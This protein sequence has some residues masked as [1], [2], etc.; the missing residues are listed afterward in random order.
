MIIAA[1]SG[2][3]KT[4]L[5]K[6]YPQKVT[7]FVCMPYKNYLDDEA[8]NNEKGKANPDN[9]LRLEWPLNYVNA[10]VENDD[11]NRILLIPS[12]CYVLL[13]LQCL[14]IPYTLC[15]PQRKAKKVY[16]KRFIKRGNTKDFIDIFIGGWDKF[17]DGLE[18][19]SYGR[20]VVLKLNQFLSDVIDVEA[21]NK[22]KERKYAQ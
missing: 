8:E 18:N 17:M 16:H 7:D 20:H 19:D 9:I 10:I 21:E 12:D 13:S 2:V 22:N 5:A 14:K 11:K 1:F 3:G 4:T 15:Y 6:L